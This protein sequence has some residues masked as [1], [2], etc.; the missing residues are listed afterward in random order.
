MVRIAEFKEK[1]KD[2]VTSGLFLSSINSWYKDD[3]IE[4]VVNRIGKYFPN[5]NNNSQTSFAVT[6]DILSDMPKCRAKVVDEKTGEY[7]MV[8]DDIT[9]KETAKI[10][11]IENP[12][13]VTIFYKGKQDESSDEIQC[14]SLSNLY[15]LLKF[16]FEQGGMDMSPFSSGFWFSREELE[17]YLSNL[18]FIGKVEKRSLSGNSYFV[19]IPEELPEK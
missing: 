11:I 2:A 5:P 7:V 17:E 19:L 12:S 9:G 8:E 10:E 13:Q 4:M 15:P 1:G 16:A 14:P 18:H 3:G 6:F